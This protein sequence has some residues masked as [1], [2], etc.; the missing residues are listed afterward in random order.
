MRYLRNSKGVTVLELLVGMSL[1]VLVLGVLYQF[2]TAG[3]KAAGT[4]KDVMQVQ[5]DMRA[6]LDNMVDEIRW[7][8]S[9]TAA[10]ATSISVLIPQNTPFSASSPYTAQ[11][12]YDASGKTV[13]RRVDAGSGF[14]NTLPIAYN[15][16]KLDGSA[17]LS[18]EYFNS[19]GT[20]LGSTPSDLTAIARVRLT[21]TSTKNNSSRTLVGDVA[22]RAR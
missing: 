16:R 15:I 22:L 10:S 8:Q 4:A 5:G 20:S 9:V 14:G 2:L 19:A 3:E 6:A 1:L 21:L 18:I 13:T 11:F 7:A 17:G 12:A